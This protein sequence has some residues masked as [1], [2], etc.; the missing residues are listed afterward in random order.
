MHKFKDATN[1]SG[2]LDVFDIFEG[3]VM[4]NLHSPSI[5]TLAIFFLTNATQ[6]GFM[7]GRHNELNR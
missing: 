1:E 2:I 4:C 7:L 5:A 6:I 3:L